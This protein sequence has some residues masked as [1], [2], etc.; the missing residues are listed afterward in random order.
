ME[1]RTDGDMETELCCRNV[2]THTGTPVRD[3]FCDTKKLQEQVSGAILFPIP[4][5]TQIATYV[6]PGAVFPYSRIA[7]A[8]RTNCRCS[9]GATTD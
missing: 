5:S 4:V 6:I 1:A 2:V 3:V 8:T 7:G 9:I